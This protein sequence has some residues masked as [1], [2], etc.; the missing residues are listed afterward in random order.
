MASAKSGTSAIRA[1]IALDL[2]PMCVRR[3]ARVAERL[4][5]AKGV[6]NATWTPPAKMHLTLKFFE[7]IDPAAARAVF[8]DLRPMVEGKRAPR[9]G[10][11]RLD[12]FP[13]AEDARIV[14]VVIEDAAGDIA[15]LAKAADERA[16]NAGIAREERPFRPHVTLARIKRPFDARK[17]FAALSSSDHGECGATEL[18]LYESQTTAQGSIYTALERARF[19]S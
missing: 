3:I 13:R 11:M 2:E 4:R 9:A 10:S 5:T 12:A 6:P 17:W 8:E 19:K 18:V 1:F 7:A 15:R 14:V 16:A